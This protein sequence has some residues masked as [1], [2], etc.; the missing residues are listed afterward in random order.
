MAQVADTTS[1][2]VGLKFRWQDGI[3]EIVEYDRPHE[4]AQR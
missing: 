1:F 3:W 2:Y 4:A